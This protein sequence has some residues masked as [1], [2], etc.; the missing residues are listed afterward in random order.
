MYFQNIDFYYI[1]T[2]VLLVKISMIPLI[3]SLSLN[4]YLNLLVYDQNIFRSSSK[5]FSNLRKF[6]KMFGNVHVTFG[7]VLEKLRKSSEGGGKSLENRQKNR[8]QYVYII[9]RT[10]HVSSKIRILCSRGKNI[11]F[12]SS[13]QRAISPIK[14]SLSFYHLS[15]L[16]E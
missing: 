3:S 15:K 13:R 16:K 5:V 6:R 8:H 4:L 11:K 2:S 10:L 14:F 9:K 12:I 7:Q 1:D